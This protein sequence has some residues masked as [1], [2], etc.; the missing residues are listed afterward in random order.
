[1]N[2]RIC[3]P[4]AWLL[5]ST[6]IIASANAADHRIGLRADFTHADGACES[7]YTKC[8]K[9]I[10][11]GGLFYNYAWTPNWEVE[12]GYDYYGQVD[13]TYPA[14]ADPSVG[15]DYEAD[16]LGLTATLGYR[17]PVSDVVSL[18]GKAGVLA[19][20]VSTDGKEIGETVSNDD[21]GFSPVVGVGIDWD[22]TPRWRTGLSYQFANNVGDEKTSG[23][24]LH[25]LM[26]G[27]S[28]RFSADP[29]PV[30][31]EPEPEPAPEPIILET[32]TLKV[33]GTQSN[34]IFEFN[35]AKLR[36]DMIAAF[37]PMLKHLTQYPESLVRVETHTDNVGSDKYN[38][39]LSERRAQ[40]V[41]HYFEQQGIT[42]D[43]I[44]YEAFGETKPLVSNDTP[45]NRAMNRRVVLTS[46]QFTRKAIQ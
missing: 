2:Q 17:Y 25:T 39:Q 36:P 6:F 18:V 31:V 38:M 23:A 33:D 5:A 34:A 45:E 12:V 10:I 43:R 15:A 20:H 21:D 42:P 14:V 27:I 22:F 19:W 9:D 3:L 16:V 11:G 13:A 24:D 46:P 40:S 1:M 4:A 26:L 7:Q 35:S 28:Y 37:Q 32:F 41:V 44:S 30:I 8:D 29:Q